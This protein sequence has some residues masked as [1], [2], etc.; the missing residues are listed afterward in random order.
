MYILLNFY[1]FVSIMRALEVL[2]VED[3]EGDIFLISEAMEGLSVPV[4]LCVKK[5]G[6]AAIDYLVESAQKTTDCL[7][8]LILLDINLPKMNGHEVLQFIKQDEKLRHLPVIM[9]TTSTSPEDVLT[10]YQ[11]YASSYV[12]KSSPEQDLS[13]VMT[14]LEDFWVNLAKLPSRR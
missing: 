8:D 1:M 4:K 6:Q 10:A 14:I 11:H 5:D 3:N 2:L 12:T 9:L 13:G 7:P